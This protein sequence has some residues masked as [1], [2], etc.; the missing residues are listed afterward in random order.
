MAIGVLHSDF[1]EPDGVERQG[2]R[3]RTRL[4]CIAS[5]V[6]RPVAV[7][8]PRLLKASA[9]PRS[10]ATPAARSSA[11]TSTA[12]RKSRLRLA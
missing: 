8:I 2:N 5:R 7:G 1:S 4:T 12:E 3:A 11:M 9:M 10:V 6:P